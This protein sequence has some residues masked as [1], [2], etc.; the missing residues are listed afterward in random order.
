MTT[1]VA[2]VGAGASDDAAATAKRAAPASERVKRERFI[3]TPA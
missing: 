2:S 1:D 3:Q